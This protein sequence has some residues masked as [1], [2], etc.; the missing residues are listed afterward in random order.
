MI[1]KMGIGK[2][3]TRRDLH[4]CGVMYNRARKEEYLD[5]RELPT[6]QFDKIVLNVPDVLLTKSFNTPIFKGSH[7]W[8]SL[9]TEVQISPTYKEFKYR[10]K[11]Q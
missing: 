1:T 6:R 3:K 9:S 7:L 10:Y 8:N 11:K 5:R 2:L 4:L